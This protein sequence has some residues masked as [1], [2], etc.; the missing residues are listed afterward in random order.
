[1]NTLNIRNTVYLTMAVFALHPFALGGWLAFIPLVKETLNLTKTELAMALLG[2]PLAV[3]PSLQI[4]SRVIANLGPRRVMAVVFPLQ[5]L[6]VLLPLLATSQLMLFVSLMVFGVTMAFLQ[7][8]LNVYA[9]RL[10]KQ[11]GAMVMN[12]C[13]G[14]WALGLM[15]G[16]LIVTWLYI[17]SPVVALAI[18]AGVSSII[19]MICALRLPKLD[20]SE[21]QIDLSVRAFA[22]RNN[23]CRDWCVGLRGRIGS[24][25]SQR[26]LVESQIGRCCIGAGYCCPR[27]HR[28]ASS[29]TAT[30]AVSGFCGIRFRGG[31][32][33]C[34]VSI[35]G[36]GGCR[37]R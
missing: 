14:F 6:A 21:D 20:G 19:A 29:Y 8:C 16:P 7:V 23:L 27:H 34:R 30:S 36:F 5:A 10:E 13:H 9:G 37:T 17:V 18:S 25:A 32:G 2:L 15:A 11:T 24:G 28:I 22:C 26:G 33:L 4:A 12:R 31:G 35:G 3:V 1:M